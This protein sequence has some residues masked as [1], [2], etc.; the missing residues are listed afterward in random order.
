MK[1]YSVTWHLAHTILS[2]YP[3]V[4]SWRIHSAGIVYCLCGDRKL[5]LL[6]TEHGIMY[7][8]VRDKKAYKFYPPSKKILK[9]LLR[10]AK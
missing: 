5:R 10:R 1:K 3:E 4:P 8:Y 6:R 9:N 7:E 2:Y